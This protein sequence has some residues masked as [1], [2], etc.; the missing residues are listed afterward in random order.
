MKS[1]KSRAPIYLLVRRFSPIILILLFG[2]SLLAQYS[3]SA[4]A[5]LINQDSSYLSADQQGWEV[6]FHYTTANFGDDEEITRF[7]IMTDMGT[8]SLTQG[9]VAEMVADWE[10]EFLVTAGDNWQGRA[11]T[12][13]NN[14]SG[15]G[16]P[17]AIGDY[18]SA[19]LTPGSEAFWPSP[20][21]HDYDAGIS[22]YLT[23]FNYLPINTDGNKRYYHILQGPVQFFMLDSQGALNST[24]DMDAQKAWL[25]HNLQASTAPWKIVIFHHTAYTGGKHLP[26]IDMRWPFALWGADFVVAGHNHIYERSLQEGIRYFTAGVA[27]GTIRTGGEFEGREAYFGNSSGAI[28]VNASKTRI[29]FEYI[30]SEGTIRDTFTE[31]REGDNPLP[32]NTTADLLDFYSEAGETSEEISYMVS[33]ANLFDS[34][35]ITAPEDFQISTTSG[36][37]FVSTIT[38]TP[39]DGEITSTPIYVHFH[40]ETAGTSNG[41]ISHTSTGTDEVFVAV[42]GSAVS[43]QIF[44]P[45]IHTSNRHPNP[46]TSEA[47]SQP[48]SNLNPATV[49]SLT[50]SR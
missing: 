43:P 20:G 42:I 21:N 50:R 29:T 45:L 25:E 37:G 47:V 28:R 16:Y 36:S 19:Y 26:T 44:L 23:Y 1:D 2:F 3:Q 31:T 15:G 10:P 27:G 41:N 9:V 7:A 34:L 49:G 32:I 46:G 6:P 30:T 39:I 5:A 4:L 14:C 18:Y 8:C 40:R 12:D 38:L 35:I 11:L 33:A 48:S 17:A 13:P 22:N 24:S